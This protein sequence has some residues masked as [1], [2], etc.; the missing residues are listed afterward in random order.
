MHN[1]SI[2]IQVLPQLPAS[3]LGDGPQKTVIDVVDAVIAYIKSTGLNYMVCPF[4]T[5][6]EGPFDELL[7]IVKRSQ[8]ICIE[9]GA[10][11][12]FAYVRFVYSPKRPPLS[13]AEKVNKHRQ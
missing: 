3:H 12:V 8:E 11:S 13:M 1:A 6:V 7:T 10:D 5:T 2:A 4:E 9:E